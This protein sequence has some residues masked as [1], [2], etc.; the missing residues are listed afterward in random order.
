MF[1]CSMAAVVVLAFLGQALAGDNP[2]FIRSSSWGMRED[3]SCHKCCVGAGFR[4]SSKVPKSTYDGQYHECRCETPITIRKSPGNPCY[5][6]RVSWGE[7][8]EDWCRKCCIEKEWYNVW[9]MVKV[10]DKKHE[11]R[12]E[13]PNYRLLQHQHKIRLHNARAAREPYNQTRTL[14]AKGTR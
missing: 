8:E 1:V 4:F 2:C 7:W 12:C 6:A 5:M 11:C 9:R 10:D 14:P 3:E 13:E